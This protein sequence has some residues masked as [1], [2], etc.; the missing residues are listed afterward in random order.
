MYT[1][2]SR[3]SVGAATGGGGTNRYAAGKPTYGGGRP[4]PNIGAVSG[5]GKMGYAVR[6][7]LHKSRQNLTLQ[8][9]RFQ[10]ARQMGMN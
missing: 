4:M 10:N 9:M 3:Y 8:R 2:P 1:L 6:D 7:R 5:A